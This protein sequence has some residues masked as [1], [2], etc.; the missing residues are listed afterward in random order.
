MRFKA[1]RCTTLGDVQAWLAEERAR[2]TTDN[3]GPARTATETHAASRS[4]PVPVRPCP[5]V[6]P[7][8]WMANT[9][10][11]LLNLACR[12]LDRQLASQSRHFLEEGGFTERLYR[13]RSAKRRSSGPNLEG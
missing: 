8:A 5:S 2:H 1:R 7:A 13:L 12:L 10:L 9:A 4:V 11:S 6:S 3:R